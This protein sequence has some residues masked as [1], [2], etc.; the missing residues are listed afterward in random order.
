MGGSENFVLIEMRRLDKMYEEVVSILEKCIKI[1]PSIEQEM[2]LES[3]GREVMVPNRAKSSW[4]FLSH[5]CAFNLE[6]VVND[7]HDYNYLT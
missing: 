5:N 6:F 3:M 2:N 1:L 7:S 4:L